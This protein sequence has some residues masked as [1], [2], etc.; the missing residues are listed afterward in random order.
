MN[1]QLYAK[2]ELQL[3]R[4]SLSYYH[5]NLH[6]SAFYCYWSPNPILL[7][8]SALRPHTAAETFVCA[9]VWRIWVVFPLIFVLL[10]RRGLIVSVLISDPRWCILKADRILYVWLPV[11]LNLLSAAWRD[12]HQNQTRRLFSMERTR[13]L[14]LGRFW[15]GLQHIWWNYEL[16]LEW[17]RSAMVAAGQWE[18]GAD[19]PGILGFTVYFTAQLINNWNIIHEKMWTNHYSKKN[20]CH[21]YSS[22]S[23]LFFWHSCSGHVL[24]MNFSFEPKISTSTSRQTFISVVQELL[25]Q[26]FTVIFYS[27]NYLQC[28][29]LNLSCDWVFLPSFSMVLL[30]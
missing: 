8:H 14:L 23:I 12:F 24:N 5:A 25:L 10:T 9:L 6:C 21:F 26:G 15:N 29:G 17:A 30:L 7:F 3:L 2:N 18:H 19:V 27:H 16:W 4:N 20:V 11:W 13:E 22:Y 1:S 28:L